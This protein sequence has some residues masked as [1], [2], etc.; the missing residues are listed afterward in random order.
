MGLDQIN[1]TTITTFLVKLTFCL[2]FT[3]P[4]LPNA[5]Q[6]IVFLSFLLSLTIHRLLG[7]E[8]LSLDKSKF[9]VI[10]FLSGYYALYLICFL[11][12]TS[13]PFESSLL[14]SSILLAI[15]PFALVKFNFNILDEFR[16]IAVWVFTL[17]CLCLMFKLTNY[18]VEGVKLSH[19]YFKD[20]IDFGNFED[21]NILQYIFTSSSEFIMSVSQWGYFQDNQLIE[22]N[23]HHTYISAVLLLNIIFILSS[24]K[25]SDIKFFITL[26]IIILLS[27]CLFIL[28]LDSKINVFLL[29]VFFSGLF[30]NL[31]LQK[32]RMILIFLVFTLISTAIYNYHSIVS[33]L[34]SAL[35]EESIRFNLYKKTLPLIKD[36]FYIGIGANNLSFSIDSLMS[37]DT[38]TYHYNFNSYETLKTTHSQYLHYQLSGGVILLISF[39][40]TGIFILYKLRG[41]VYAMNAFCIVFLNC[42]FE[43]F[44]TRSWG[45]YTFMLMLIYYWNFFENKKNING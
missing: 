45:V 25:K 24:I 22:L 26:K 42:L 4:A 31:I 37:K 29:G 39:L 13:T 14:Q 18:W 5:L 3:F 38:S 9:K 40:M 15:V 41:E 36:N 8:F 27:L 33:I 6:S 10:I 34:N 35:T 20:K 11:Y 16:R 12:E 7:K 1:T 21:K 17:S 43:D 30:L 44:L 2:L 23:T 28:Y 19:Y 32:S